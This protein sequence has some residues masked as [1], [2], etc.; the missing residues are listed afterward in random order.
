MKN[1][2]LLNQQFDEIQ[3][4]V[5]CS[6]M[7]RRVAQ[8]ENVYN[9]CNS[10]RL[11]KVQCLKKLVRNQAKEQ[12]P[13]LNMDWWLIY[14]YKNRVRY[15]KVLFSTSQN[16]AQKYSYFITVAYV[17][18]VGGGEK[19]QGFIHSVS[20]PTCVEKSR[21]HIDVT[22]SRWFHSSCPVQCRQWELCIYSE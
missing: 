7:K 4:V 5:L 11:A 18:W 14:W 15:A 6:T 17:G 1:S 19:S 10:L 20:I 22:T 3:R 21:R 2:F 13:K 16:T 9:K 12:Y 8:L